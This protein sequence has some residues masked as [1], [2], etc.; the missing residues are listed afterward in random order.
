MTD[1][2]AQIIRDKERRD[3]VASALA[4]RA[5]VAKS[6]RVIEA[7]EVHEWLLA[8]AEGRKAVRPRARK[9]LK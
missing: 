8:R 5:E 3:F 1:S 6:G 7:A 4:A 2:L 9:L